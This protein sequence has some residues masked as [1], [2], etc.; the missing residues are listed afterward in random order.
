MQN[1]AHSLGKNAGRN[2]LCFDRIQ[3]ECPHLLNQSAGDFDLLMYRD[4]GPIV[5]D[6]NYALQLYFFTKSEQRQC[7]NFTGYSNTA[8]D[9]YV[10]AGSQVVDLQERIAYHEKAQLQ[11]LDDAP[12]IFVSNAGF[13]A[14]ASAKIR[15]AAFEAPEGMRFWY[16]SV[17]P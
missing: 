12:W 14:G 15:G 2:R 17:A 16:M 3:F 4:G 13:Q 1:L 10:L 11:V 9:D 8:N 5:A 6:V 7:C